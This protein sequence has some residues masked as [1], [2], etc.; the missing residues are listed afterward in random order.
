MFYTDSLTLKRKKIESNQETV[1]I[2]R[3]ARDWVRPMKSQ[4][5]EYAKLNNSIFSLRKNHLWI[6]YLWNRKQTIL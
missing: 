5:W 3:E 6:K 4:Q 1:K 2:L